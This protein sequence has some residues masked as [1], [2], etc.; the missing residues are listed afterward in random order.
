MCRKLIWSD[1]LQKNVYIKLSNR[2]LRTIRREG[3]LDNYLLDDRP[4][5][6]K[7]LGLFG[8]RLRYQVMQSPRM[9][10][11]MEEERK[12]LGLPK[13]PTFEEWLEEKKPE[14]AERV[15]EYTNIR[16]KTEPFY[17]RTLH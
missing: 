11:K 8:W 13:P 12:S 10:E 6:I 17:S 7:E 2:V 16:E 1:A 4:K 9:K 3:G 15:K 14:L 5:R